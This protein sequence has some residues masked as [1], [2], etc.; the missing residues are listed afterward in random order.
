M[1]SMLATGIA[2]S[3]LRASALAVMLLREVSGWFRPLPV[4]LSFD[5]VHLVDHALAHPGHREVER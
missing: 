5:G 4:Q 2:R 3:E 1:S